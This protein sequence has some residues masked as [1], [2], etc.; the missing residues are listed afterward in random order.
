MNENTFQK[1]QSNHLNNCVLS[2]PP[3]LWDLLLK[4]LWLLI[5]LKLLEISPTFSIS[6]NYTAYK[7]RI[8]QEGNKKVSHL[9]KYSNW[10]QHS[11]AS[12]GAI[13]HRADLAAN[14]T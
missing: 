13:I 7:L 12:K 9:A 3:F 14:P 5:E 11:C 8:F 4:D 2:R 6:A 1:L 10:Q